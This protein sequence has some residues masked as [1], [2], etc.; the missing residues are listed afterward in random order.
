MFQMLR[1]AGVS[2]ALAAA[3]VVATRDRDIQSE[4]EKRPNLEVVFG[5]SQ[6]RMNAAA[7]SSR[8]DT[9]RDIILK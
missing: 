1:L 3:L 7:A 9:H 6:P 5:E 2:A 8:T 4:L